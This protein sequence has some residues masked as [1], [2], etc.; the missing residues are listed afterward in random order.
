[1]QS[2]DGEMWIVVPA[3][4][5]VGR[6]KPVSAQDLLAAQTAVG[7]K[8]LAS[9]ECLIMPFRSIEMAMVN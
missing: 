5:Y 9:I 1:M 4:A 7:M 3:K 2:D 8:V 6:V